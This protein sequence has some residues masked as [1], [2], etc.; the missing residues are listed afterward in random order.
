MMA[1]VGVALLALAGCG[2]SSDEAAPSWDRAAPQAEPGYDG[3][4]LS[5]TAAAEAGNTEEAAEREVVTNGSL[6]LVPD[7]PATAIDD[8]VALIDR[9]GGR[10]DGRS[11]QTANEW[12]EASA[13]LT[14]RVP[15]GELTDTIAEVEELGDVTDV[16]I[17]SD[18]VTRQ[19]RDLDARITALEAS[20]DR[21]LDLMTDADSSEALIAAEDALSQ[22]Q[23]DLESLRSERS[24]LSDQVA[25]STLEVSV[26]AEQ[27][28]EFKSD[29][30]VGGLQSG[31]HSLVNFASA[32]L[33]GIG[34]ALPW[35]VIIGLPLTVVIV[36][37]RRRRRVSGHEPHTS[38]DRRQAS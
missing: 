14:V 32:A 9:V 22:R 29:G 4:M 6:T 28:V 8:I 24:Y 26:V 10:V 18:D 11:E 1:L 7:D 17:N 23:A 19:G 15:A 12:R 2:S 3:E 37:L 30:F 27:V 25:M 34:A 31:W 36:L 33:V 16:S 20:T 5:D 21:L 35:I 38:V 13:W